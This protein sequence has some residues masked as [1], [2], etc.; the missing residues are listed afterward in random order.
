VDKNVCIYH[1]GLGHRELPNRKLLSLQN[2]SH[3]V[4]MPFKEVLEILNKILAPACFKWAQFP[5]A[6][7]IV[8]FKNFIHM[9]CVRT[10]VFIVCF[11]NPHALSAQRLMKFHIIGLGSLLDRS[12]IVT[13]DFFCVWFLLLVT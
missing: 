3:D 11:S 6:F 7:E 8:R 12:I 4:H 1:T 2:A 9:I 13:S 5:S 10:V